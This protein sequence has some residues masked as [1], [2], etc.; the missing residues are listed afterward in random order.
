MWRE[1]REH[2]ICRGVI[3]F[4]RMSCDKNVENQCLL[5]KK[6]G[7]EGEETNQTVAHGEYRIDDIYT[8]K[9]NHK[10]YGGSN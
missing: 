4:S 7:L 1:R 10:Y 2:D 3:G 6:I 9:K 5:L 8:L